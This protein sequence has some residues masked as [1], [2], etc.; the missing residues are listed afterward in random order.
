MPIITA[1]AMLSSMRVNPNC[2]LKC[3]LDFM[4]LRAV[5]N[6][7]YCGHKKR[8]SNAESLPINDAICLALALA[9]I[10]GNC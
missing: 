3:D 8:D 5:I 10:E 2:R 7:G 9:N 1:S 4:G 6:F